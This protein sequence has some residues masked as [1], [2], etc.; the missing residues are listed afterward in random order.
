[1][2]EWFTDPAGN[3]HFFRVKK[4]TAVAKAKKGEPVVAPAVV[5]APIEVAAEGVIL[6]PA[7]VEKR[8]AP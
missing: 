8:T 7:V 4:K 2:Y 5:E 6:E 3:R 1:M